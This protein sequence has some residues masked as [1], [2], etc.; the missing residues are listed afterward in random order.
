M[1][2]SN[3]R[4]P[5][6]CHIARLYWRASIRRLSAPRKWVV[7]RGGMAA[8]ES[9]KAV[10]QAMG[11]PGPKASNPRFSVLSPLQS[12]T[13]KKQ[14]KKRKANRGVSDLAIEKFSRTTL[15]GRI[16]NTTS[17]G[18]AKPARAHHADPCKT[19]RSIRALSSNAAV[20]NRSAGREGKYHG[21]IRIRSLSIANPGLCLCAH[22]SRPEA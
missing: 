14:G 4:V 17:I 15:P 19:S 12:I 20:P 11:C 18:E 21:K 1:K 2:S 6:S 7:L 10:A 9:S 22:R 8:P 16:Q 5:S 3:C 13:N